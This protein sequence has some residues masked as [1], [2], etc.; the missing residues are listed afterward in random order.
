MKK[1]ILTL[2]LIIPAVAL[3]DACDIENIILL[4]TQ[5]LAKQAKA[6]QKDVE[7]MVK[8]NQM[9]SDDLVIATYQLNRANEL[10]NRAYKLYI[11]C[12]RKDMI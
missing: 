1:F 2:W 8:L 4:N 7:A 9:A 6:H 3:A 5:L 10:Y 11:T 12:A